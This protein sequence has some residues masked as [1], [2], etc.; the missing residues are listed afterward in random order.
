MISHRRSMRIVT[1]GSMALCP[2][3]R[4]TP[5]LMIS[6]GLRGS[7]NG[8]GSIVIPRRG[9]EPPLLLETGA[10]TTSRLL[11]AWWKSRPQSAKPYFLYVHY[12][13]PH[14]SYSPPPAYAAKFGVAADDPLLAPG[15]GMVTFGRKVPEAA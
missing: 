8:C 1:T 7:R 6:I 4:H 15:Q 5:A 12:F 2:H 9:A 14:A 13:D 10:F 11:L 3:T